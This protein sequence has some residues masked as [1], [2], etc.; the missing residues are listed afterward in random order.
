MKS[1]PLRLAAL[2][3]LTSLIGWLDYVTGDELD[4]FILYYVPIVW[5]AWKIGPRA[6][7]LVAFYGTT[8]W[9]SANVYLGHA[10][11]HPTYAAWGALVMLITFS[12]AALASSRIHYLLRRERQLNRE[13]AVALAKVKKLSGRLPICIGCKSI[14]DDAGVWREI[15]EYFTMQSEDDFV[16]SQTVCPHCRVPE[17]HDGGGSEKGP[18]LAPASR[19]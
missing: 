6:G 17:A 15:E 11:S 14:R 5:A 19:T 4:L 9:V 16:F 1:T 13:L 10:Y 18:L 12:A 8:L 7:A 3:F 2:L